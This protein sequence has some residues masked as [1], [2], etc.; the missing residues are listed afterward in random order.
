[1]QAFR[2]PVLC[3]AGLGLLGTRV[4]VCTPRSAFTAQLTSH[5]LRVDFL[6]AP[7]NN[8]IFLGVPATL[9]VSLEELLFSSSSRPPGDHVCPRAPSP[10]P[11]R[12]LQGTHAKCPVPVC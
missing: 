1:M 8:R 3:A 9:L 4:Q 12:G 6:S 2:S 11:W 7:L 10:L 5:L